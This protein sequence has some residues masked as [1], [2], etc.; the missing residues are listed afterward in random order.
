MSGP[1]APTFGAYRRRTVDVTRL[2]SG[3]AK[4]LATM[5]DEQSHPRQQHP[6]GAGAEDDNTAIGTSSSAAAIS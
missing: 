3:G 6:H 2:T 1:E 5:F 4:N